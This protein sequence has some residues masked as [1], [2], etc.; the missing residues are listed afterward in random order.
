MNSNSKEDPNYME[1]V[2]DVSENSV[3]EPKVKF[4]PSATNEKGNAYKKSRR[5]VVCS[6]LTVAY[7]G[8]CNKAFY[9][10]VGS[11]KHNCT[12]LINHIK[13]KKRG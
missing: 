6:K 12:C 7:C 9:Y 10:A 2:L 11:K 13:M 8:C 1:E 3:K 5:R 4:Y